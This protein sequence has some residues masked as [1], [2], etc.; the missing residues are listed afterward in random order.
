MAAADSPAA[1]ACSGSPAR[2]PSRGSR[3]RQDGDQH[4]PARAER[5]TSRSATRRPRAPEHL[6]RG[7]LRHR[8]IDRLGIGSVV[9][10]RRHRRRGSSSGQPVAGLRRRVPPGRRAEGRG[11]VPAAPATRPWPLPATRSLTAAAA[12]RLR[13]GMVTARANACRWTSP[14][15]SMWRVAQ[16]ERPAVR[17]AW[18]RR[19]LL[20]ARRTR[21]SRPPRRRRRAGFPAARGAVVPSAREAE[22]TSAV[23]SSAPSRRPPAGRLHAEEGAGRGGDHAATDPGGAP[24]STPARRRPPRSGCGRGTPSGSAAERPQREPH[25]TVSSRTRATSARRAGRWTVTGSR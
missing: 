4:Q 25:T 19:R 7:G 21:C 10:L 6:T 9:L 20:R 14:P 15:R 13:P 24:R 16:L 8:P 5:S 11:L 18:P 2:S 23:S 12:A 3:E 17:R 1:P 22:E